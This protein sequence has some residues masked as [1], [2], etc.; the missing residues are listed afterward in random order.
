MVVELRID[1]L[2]LTRAS[3]SLLLY[4]DLVSVAS[5][6]LL[7]DDGGIVTPSS[8]IDNVFLQ[9]IVE[10]SIIGSSL[11][12]STILLIVYHVSKLSLHAI[13]NR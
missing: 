7:P 6:A 4:D 2:V 13:C 12:H 1:S 11:Y 5:V 9:N 10:C 8:R 3:N